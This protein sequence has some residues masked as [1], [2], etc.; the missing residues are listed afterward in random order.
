MVQANGQLLY[1]DGSPLSSYG[2]RFLGSSLEKSI[3]A[4]SIAAK[5]P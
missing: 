5:S 3:T 2:A 4:A 1:V